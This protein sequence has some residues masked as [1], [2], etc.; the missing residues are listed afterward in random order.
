MQYIY[1]DQSVIIYECVV[2]LDAVNGHI[3]PPPNHQYDCVFSTKNSNAKYSK[4][5]ALYE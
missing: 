5:T 4:H 3:Q 1:V 2:N